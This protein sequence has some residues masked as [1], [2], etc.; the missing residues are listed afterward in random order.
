MNANTRTGLLRA[1]M[2]RRMND[3]WVVVERNAFDMVMTHPVPPPWWR[4]ALEAINPL[5]WV[6]GM[7]PLFDRVQRRLH[8][9]VDEDGALSRITSGEVPA[10]WQRHF[11]WEVPDGTSRGSNQE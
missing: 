5:V 2:M 6:G 8:V 10:S 3:G 9:S 1:E 7:T 4:T 11:S